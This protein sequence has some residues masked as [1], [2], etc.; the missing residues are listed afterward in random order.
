MT[1]P[2][3]P[4]H[5]PPRPAPRPVPGGLRITIAGLGPVQE[6]CLVGLF[7]LALSWGLAELLAAPGE[8]PQA[9]LSENYRIA[10]HP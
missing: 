1:A 10:L 6:A 9:H 8:A 7:A 5:I 3:D 4:N 2:L